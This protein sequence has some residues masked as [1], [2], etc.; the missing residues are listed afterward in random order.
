[1]TISRSRNPLSYNY[2]VNDNTIEKV[3]KFHDLGVTFN[4]KFDFNDDLIFRISKA[5]STVGVIKRMAHEFNYPTA[6][7]TL[8]TALVRSK[9]EYC[10]VVW[11]PYY[12]VATNSIE[13]IQKS[14]L[15]F[16]N[17]SNESTSY[18]DL[19]KKFGFDQLHIRRKLASILFCFDLL[20]NNIDSS[21]LLGQINLHC[22][23]RIFRSNELLR[24]IRHATNYLK[25]SPINTMQ[26]NFNLVQECFDYDVTNRNTFKK[27]SLNLLIDL[28]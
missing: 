10:S 6:L 18:N 4:C 27:A 3:N 14:F 26:F 1:M 16:L 17:R 9:L 8:Y 11:S 2:T 25:Y 23:T 21:E 20:R 28:M 7:K 22:P 24:P 19:C 12:T 5:K 13:N 15:R